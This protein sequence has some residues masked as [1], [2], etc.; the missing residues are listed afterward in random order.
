[1]P[2]QVAAAHAAAAHHQRMIEQR[3]TAVRRRLQRLEK[4]REQLGLAGVDTRLLGDQ[5]RVVAVVRSRGCRKQP[6]AD[7]A[8]RLLLPRA[9]GMNRSAK[10]IFFSVLSVDFTR[11]EPLSALRCT[12]GVGVP[13]VVA[14]SLHQSGAGVFIAVGAVS[15][16]FGSFQGAYRSRA[17]TMVFASVGMAISIFVGSLFG[18]S[19]P[20]SAIVAAVWGFAAGLLVALGPPGGY[21][22]LQCA[23][24]AIVAGAYPADLSGATSR[25]ALV[26]LGGAIQTFFVVAVWPLRR[27]SAER[28]IVGRVYRSLADYA[29]RLPAVGTTT[30]PDPHVFADAGA[31]H[32]DPHPF[33]RAHEVLVFQ[34]L[35][36]EAER[37]RT[38]LASLSISPARGHP[39]V[40]APLAA[41]LTEIAAAVQEGRAPSAAPLEWDTL[42][43]AA[44]E[45]RQLGTPIDGVLGQLRA[46]WRTAIVPSEIE[47]HETHAVRRIR[48]I[49]PVRDAFTTLR[50]NLTLRSN[51]CRHALRLAAALA[52]ATAV[53]RLAALP[54]GYWF[55]M[56]TLLVLKPE[57]RE[58]FVTGG[59]RILGTLAGAGLA[60]V[61][62]VALGTHH[63]VLTVLLLAFVW[64]GYS[65]FRA[66]YTIYT[67]CI[68]GYVVLLLTL[69]GVAHPAATAWVRALN[70]ALGGALG[71]LVYRLWPSW[72]SAHV[73]SLLGALFDALGRDAR[74]LF[75]V[76]VN[77]ARWDPQ[78]L[79]ESRTDARLARSNAEASVERML[80]EPAAGRRFDP[81]LALGLLA[82][83]RRYALGALA[84]HARLERAPQQP[85]RELET[86]G[87]QI[88]GSLA[89]IAQAL[90][91]N[92]PVPP[93]P[94]LRDAQLA[95]EASSP[96]VAAETDMMVDSVNM[97]A[98]LLA[99]PPMLR[100]SA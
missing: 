9:G 88:G 19:T 97:M 93:L 32:D 15:V 29:R 67:V 81:Q 86:L 69:A 100:R 20:L 85:H 17:M 71:L 50:A 30:P 41:L 40:V 78:V 12:I 55:A 2:V 10:H 34:A 44:A 37:L 28:K 65:L 76:Y 33:A 6:A 77:P 54:R 7:A 80:G 99:R 87:E 95:V 11:F 36:D 60:T 63:A 46:A 61:L 26:L 57:F 58:T 90:R 73:P 56:T 83:A 18:Y 45:L 8:E 47:P 25:A 53:Y 82:A 70:T 51:P 75:R 42:N 84:L 74:L 94:H 98:A 49:P 59:A 3:A 52:F 79:R 5:I 22:G 64:S 39:R 16:G 38:G 13:L 21:T 4:V 92:T 48:T 24:A 23:V 43:S 1:M 91:A 66:N 14:L 96:H 68:T 27:F 89:A 62:V 31:V 72:E 35:L